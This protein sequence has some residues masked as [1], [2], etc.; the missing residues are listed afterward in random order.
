MSP[1]TKRSVLFNRPWSVRFLADHVPYMTF[2]SALR[3]RKFTLRENA[4][5][6]RKDA[7][8]QLSMKAPFTGEV[9][10]REL[11]TDNYTFKEVAIEQNYAHAAK[12]APDAKYILDI[13]ANI[14]LA[15]RYFS[16]VFPEVKL[17]CVEP[18]PDNF[19]MLNRNTL[20][21][22]KA[23]RVKTIQAAVWMVDGPV[24]VGLPPEG[25]GF[26]AVQVKDVVQGSGGRM[27]PGFTFASLI[28]QSGFPHIDLLKL[29]VEGAEAHL[30]EE[31]ASWLPKVNVLAIEFHHDTRKTSRFDQVMQEHGFIIEDQHPHTVLAIR[32][33][34]V[35]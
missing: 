4:N 32:K 31:T 3:Y 28:Q 29:D 19:A 5:Q 27:V 35:R 13:G 15:T 26:D 30:F 1:I 22:Q 33:S 24:D 21:L 10:L 7:V 20:E 23:G 14:G 12:A 25:G 6:Q 17:F 11:G 9:W 34:K 16:A 8:V 18:D 2:G